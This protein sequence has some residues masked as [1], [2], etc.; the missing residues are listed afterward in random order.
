MINNLTS[1]DKIMNSTLVCFHPHAWKKYAWGSWSKVKF[2]WVNQRKPQVGLGTFG[3]FNMVRLTKVGI[4]NDEIRVIKVYNPNYQG[5][6][7]NYIIFNLLFMLSVFHWYVVYTYIPNNTCY[8]PVL[9]GFFNEKCLVHSSSRMKI[10]TVSV[11]VPVS[12]KNYRI[13]NPVPLVVLQKQKFKFWFWFW[14]WQLDM[15]L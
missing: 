8:L 1:Y 10:S 4:V 15:V 9:G 5:M 7:Q 2:G 6:L 12:C 13:R 3:G 11:L 14:F